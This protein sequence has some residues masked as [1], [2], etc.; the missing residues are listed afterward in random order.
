MPYKTHNF[1]IKKTNQSSHLYKKI[2]DYSDER[3]KPPTD[4]LHV[5]ASSTLT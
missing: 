4:L 5:T 2:S 1:S 3:M